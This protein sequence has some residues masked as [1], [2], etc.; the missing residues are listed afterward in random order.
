MKPRHS[1]PRGAWC[2]AFEPERRQP[3]CPF[4]EM[5]SSHAESISGSCGRIPLGKTQTLDLHGLHRRRTQRGHSWREAQLGRG[6]QS[7]SLVPRAGLMWWWLCRCHVPAGTR[8][9]PRHMQ[10][11]ASM[12][13]AGQI[14][15]CFASAQNQS[16]PLGTGLAGGP[17]FPL[18]Q[19][20]P[21]P[22]PPS[23]GTQ[24]SLCPPPDLR[25]PGFT[26]WWVNEI[27]EP[28]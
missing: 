17:L 22:L 11:P 12:H 2:W 24:F 8:S 6:L 20:A 19:P 13:T 18:S 23:A 9:H 7:G 16:L 27:S 1:T 26:R 3:I 4:L 10:A 25:T 21:P 5:Q 28:W 14:F 15:P